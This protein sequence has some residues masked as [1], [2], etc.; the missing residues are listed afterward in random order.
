MDIPTSSSPQSKLTL[1]PSV[2]THVPFSRTFLLTLAVIVP[3]FQSHLRV[4]L[5]LP[6]LLAPPGSISWFPLESIAL[7]PPPAARA[8]AIKWMEIT[9]SLLWPPHLMDE[10]S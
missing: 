7:P 10:P 2:K 1:R 6:D 9:A 8:S 5:N 4:F 3:D